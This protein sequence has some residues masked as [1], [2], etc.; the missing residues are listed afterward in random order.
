MSTHAPTW[1]PCALVQTWPPASA[2][3]PQ[4]APFVC[5]SM[6]EPPQD[7]SPV[8]QDWHVPALHA[9][10]VPQALPQEPQLSPSV[11]VSV[12]E[13]PHSVWPDPQ[14]WH[15]P[16]SQCPA[17]HALPHFPQFCGSVW[18]LVQ[19][20]SSPLPHEVSGDEHAADWQTPLV[21]LCPEVQAW[22]HD[23]QLA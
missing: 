18:R 6:Q 20:E 4:F 23:P 7:V 1:Q 10:P 22:P 21:Q 15:A 8:P 17:S 11:W 5:V 19:L 9:T 16:V 2:Q 13:L 12:Q 14:G 3:P